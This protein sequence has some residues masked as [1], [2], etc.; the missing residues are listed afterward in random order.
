MLCRRVLQFFI[1]VHVCTCIACKCL[2]EW[3]GLQHAVPTIKQGLCNAV[4]L[5]SGEAATAIT[6][7]GVI[8]AKVG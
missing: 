3:A 6:L 8:I 2:Q 1:S 7:D 5:L 4:R